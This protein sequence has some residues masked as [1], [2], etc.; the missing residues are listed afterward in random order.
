MK[1]MA[2][3]SRLLSLF[4]LLLAAC[5]PA[6]ATRIAELTTPTAVPHNL[7]VADLLRHPPAPRATVEVDAYFSGATYSPVPGA[8]MSTRCPS[9]WNAA[10]TDRP[11]VA[12]LHVLSTIS[13]NP[14]PEDAPWLIA[15]QA[16]SQTPEPGVP[17]LPYH[18]RLR[19]HLGDPVF[20]Q[21]QYAERIFVVEAV[22]QTYQK[23][24]PGPKFPF[25]ELPEDYATWLPYHDPTLGYSLRYPPDWQIERMDDA[26]LMLRALEWRDYPVKVT[27]HP[28]ETHEDIYNPAS[29]PSLLKGGSWGVFGQGGMF[30]GT[31]ETQQLDG[32][33]VER[34]PSA[35]EREDGVLF[36]GS[37]RTYEL[38]LRY[39]V[40]FDAPQPLLTA[41]TIIVQG[42]RLDVLPGP[43][44]TPPVKQTLGKGPFVSR[45][46]AVA[47]AKEHMQQDFTLLKALLVP[48]VEV[49]RPDNACTA[50]IEGHFDG[51]W[52][53][54]V[55][56]IREETEFTAQWFL[57]ATNG[58]WLCGEE[59]SSNVTPYP[60]TVPPG[61]PTPAP[62]RTPIRKYDATATAA[63]TDT[64]VGSK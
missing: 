38:S 30:G 52:E 25:N 26:A 20:S 64:P 10:L 45:D 9:R 63:P 2:F 1:Q 23:E 34:E 51:I 24:A 19:E 12:Q 8:F 32:Y 6:A 50:T 5:S 60:V 46:E 43:S 42:F 4:A 44:P 29:L 57:N 27:V 15:T 47:R 53:L 31:L 11:L 14:F 3:K 41:Y 62:T 35:S 33:F 59:I 37:G 36:S 21:C 61:A 16:Q 28:G 48:E 7:G 56:Y 54:T 13:G 17:D 39:P 40:G 18:A 49:R 58:E 55:K 22:A